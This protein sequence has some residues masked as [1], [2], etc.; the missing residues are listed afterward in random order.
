[1]IWKRTLSLT[2]A[3]LLTLTPAAR[4]A[5]SEPWYAE[6][7]RFI[8]QE[9]L[10]NG[11]E[12]GFAPTAPATRAAV[13]QTLWNLEGQPYPKTA[14]M[15]SDI[16]IDAWYATAAS[17]ALENGLASG[18]HNRA[19]RGSAVITRAEFAAIFHRY[20]LNRGFPAIDLPTG[21]EFTDLDE[22]PDWGLEGMLFCVGYGI[23]G[24]DSDRLMPNAA[25]SQAE[26]AAMLMAIAHLTPPEQPAGERYLEGFLKATYLGE[27]DPDYLKLAGLTE[28]E[29]QRAYE[30]GLK[31]AANYFL[32]IYNV[33]YPND[34]MREAL[35]EIYAQVYAHLTFR[36]LS[37][38]EAEDGGWGVYLSVEPLNIIRITD[39]ALPAAMKDFY[40]KYP[41]E[42]QIQMTKKEYKAMDQEW[43]ER[44]IDLFRQR[45]PLTR[46]LTAQ[47]IYLQP[48]KNEKGFWTLDEESA[49]RLDETII[50][51]FPAT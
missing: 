40:A 43:G 41:A 39:A 37:S 46:G 8:V 1:M 42:K 23:L 14:G 11:V 12:E 26:L 47:T 36:V 15:F 19:F 20:L 45:A 38:A 3:A 24:G 22:V 51:Y 27:Y 4:C 25:A 17:W 2:L 49:K 30:K 9:G 16:S 7:E 21:E 28:K 10:M 35:T 13:F 18:D 48:Q 50:Q 31:D 29:A 6:A 33:E 32:A 44:L 5:E 34:E